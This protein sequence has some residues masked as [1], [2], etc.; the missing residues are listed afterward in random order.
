MSKETLKGSGVLM[1]QKTFDNMNDD[2]FE[3]EGTV[4]AVDYRAYLKKRVEEIEKMIDSHLIYL[5][6]TEEF[7]KHFG[8]LTTKTKIRYLIAM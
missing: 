5:H 6:G 7:K 1:Q 2:R 8:S 4:S 3:E